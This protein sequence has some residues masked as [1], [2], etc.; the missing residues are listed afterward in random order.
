M[1]PVPP[2]VAALAG[3]VLLLAPGIVLLSLLPPRDREALLPD[4]AGYLAVGTSV[5]ISA[6]I[7][8]LLAEAGRFSLPAAG[9]V[10]TGGSLVALVFGWRRLGWP[11]ERPVRLR[12][13]WPAAL[14]LA[15]AVALTAR[16]NQQIVG[17]R[18]AG[19]EVAS[20]AQLA[21]TG[22][23]EGPRLPGSNV[24]PLF[25]AYSGPS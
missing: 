2:A 8:L 21:R 25:P 9:T 17:G 15:L 1:N 24:F 7:G 3:L 20:M 10:V 4:E 23:L 11:F 18:V 16:P 19:A 22:G 12:G 14:V 6:W 5:A 13:L